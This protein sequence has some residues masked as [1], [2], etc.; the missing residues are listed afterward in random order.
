MRTFYQFIL[1]YRGKLQPDDESRLADW[2]FHEHDFPKHAV[3]YNEISE[4]IEQFSPF[5][6][7]VHVF[8]ELWQVY[9]EE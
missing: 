2:V 7:A 6:N 3:T 1:T 5:V 9:K 8:D 4:Y